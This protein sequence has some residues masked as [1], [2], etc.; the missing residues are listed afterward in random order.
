MMEFRSGAREN[1]V[2]E[3]MAQAVSEEDI[4]NINYEWKSVV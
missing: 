3:G 4:H 2:I 1:A